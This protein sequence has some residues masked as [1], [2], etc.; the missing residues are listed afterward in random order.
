MSLT[1]QAASAAA[2]RDEVHVRE[3]R[4]KYAEKFR[5]AFALLGAPLATTMPDG[6]FYFWVRTPIPDDEFAQ[7]LYRDGVLVA[8]GSVGHTNTQYTATST[9]GFGDPNG[10]NGNPAIRVSHAGLWARALSPAAAQRT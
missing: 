7:R 10:V 4:R 9:W 8:S 3:N 2:W 1:V 5:T 6:G